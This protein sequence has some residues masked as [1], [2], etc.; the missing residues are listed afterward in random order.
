MVTWPRVVMWPCHPLVSLSASPSGHKM[1]LLSPG[2]L[3]SALAWLSEIPC[4]IT[5]PGKG[6]GASSWPRGWKRQGDSNTH[7]E[8]KMAQSRKRSKVGC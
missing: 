6:E 1:A 8:W 4:A 3:V 5:H 2:W 7:R